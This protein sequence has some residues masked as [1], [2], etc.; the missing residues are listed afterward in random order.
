MISKLL[1]PIFVFIILSNFTLICGQNEVL[2]CNYYTD[3][4]F[5]YRCDLTIKNPNGLNNFSGIKGSHSTGRTDLSVKYIVGAPGSNTTNIPSIIC[6]K[7][8]N[9]TRIAYENMGIQ[10]IDDDSFRDCTG[11]Y[12]VDLEGNKIKQIHENSFQR[13]L[14][15]I[16][17]GLWHNELTQLPENLFLKLYK[18]GRL[19][20][21]FNKI[22]S[23]PTNIF[24]P[25]IRLNVLYLE[26][27]LIED[28][29]AN[30]F[31]NLKRLVELWL[32]GNKLK[33]IHGDSFGILPEL[34]IVPLHNNQISAIDE[35][36]VN[37]TG[38]VRIDIRNNL[39]VDKAI[40]DNTGPREAMRA[41]LQQCFKNYET[42]VSNP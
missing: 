30:V 26:E 38:V 28:L 2:S 14:E 23:L 33:V 29:P 41:E 16:T 15:L 5:G 12:L 4:S 20:L 1:L 25:L 18:L 13:N 34:K 10:R 11:L 35:G 3:S 36:F 31:S 32:Y 42:L 27:N 19:N 21:D 17:I 6:R 24:R 22:T 40:F 37:N 39:C 9:A 8:R 7:F